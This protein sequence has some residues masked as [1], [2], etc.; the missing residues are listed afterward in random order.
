MT[1]GCH[2]IALM[3]GQAVRQRRESGRRARQPQARSAASARRTPSH[4][5]AVWWATPAMHGVLELVQQVASAEVS[6]LVRGE[7]ARQGA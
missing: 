3:I 6:V 2:I 7:A 1:C 5:G 4:I